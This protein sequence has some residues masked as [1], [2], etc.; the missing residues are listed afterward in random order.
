V[1]FKRLR[2]GFD[3]SV[4]VDHRIEHITAPQRS[5]FTVKIRNKA[6]TVQHPESQ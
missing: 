4:E 1:I 6:R 2:Y 3:M 5:K